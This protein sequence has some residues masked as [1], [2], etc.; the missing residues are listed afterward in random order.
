MAQLKATTVNGNLTVT[1]DSINCTSGLSN[2]MIDRINGKYL[3]QA[4]GNNNPGSSLLYF[5]T[6]SKIL[7]VNIPKGKNS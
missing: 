3:Y 2:L 7:Y 6:A 4:A 5:D 1:G